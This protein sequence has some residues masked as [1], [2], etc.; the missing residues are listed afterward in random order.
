MCH[1]YLCE[2][3]WCL[4]KSIKRIATRTV[5]LHFVLN[6][7]LRWGTYHLIWTGPKVQTRKPDGK[8]MCTHTCWAHGLSWD[9]RNHFCNLPEHRHRSFS[10]PQLKCKMVKFDYFGKTVFGTIYVCIRHTPHLWCIG[11]VDSY[12]YSNNR[13]N[14]KCGCSLSCLDTIYKFS[15]NLITNLFH[16]QYKLW[17][18][19]NIHSKT[20]SGDN[21]WTYVSTLKLSQFCHKQCFYT[22]RDCNSHC[23]GP[24]Y[25]GAVAGA[26]RK[27]HNHEN[28]IVKTFWVAFC[29]FFCQHSPFT[30]TNVLCSATDKIGH[31]ILRKLFKWHE[32]D[33]V[34]MF[35]RKWTFMFHPVFMLFLCV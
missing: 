26:V 29:G 9:N 35:Y 13:W 27:H 1:P 34:H 22:L 24:I 33:H 31:V 21:R 7:I 20:L 5:S 11:K 30:L 25:R 14:L 2:T 32:T 12:F 4:G 8:F 18:G 15:Y 28:L 6:V 16:V 23:E 17:A 19:D 10:L 3:I